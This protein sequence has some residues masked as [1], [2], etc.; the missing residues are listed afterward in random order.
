MLRN[1]AIRKETQA[2]MNWVRTEQSWKNRQEDRC[3]WNGSH[4]LLALEFGRLS[5]VSRH[6]LRRLFSDF[7]L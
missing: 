7:I 5:E 4:S 2:G 1:V 3:D 6:S